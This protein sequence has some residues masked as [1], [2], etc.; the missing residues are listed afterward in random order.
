MTALVFHSLGAFAVS[1]QTTAVTAFPTDKIRALFA[2]LALEPGQPHRREALAGLFWPEMDQVTALRNLR[3]ALHRLR[4]TLDNVQP[5]VSASLFQS[6]RQTV[7]L[8]SSLIMVDVQT[9]QALL[10]ACAT[11]AH[12]S[13]VAC[14]ECNS[15]L[16]QA[17]D[18]YRGELLAGRQPVLRAFLD[19]LQLVRLDPRHADH[20]E[21]VEIGAGHGEEADPLQQGVRRVAR[22]L[23]HP[24]VE[25]QPG[26]FTVEET[27]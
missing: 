21:F 22:L 14:R 13:L 6:T 25:R 27:A 17:V 26:Q 16:V 7:Q 5:D 10:T 11:H 3:L 4:T 15:R 23:H 20:E 12:A 9:F 18:L 24:A 19:T 8:T 2:Y 1:L